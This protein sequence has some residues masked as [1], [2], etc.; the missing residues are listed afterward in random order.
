M[1]ETILATMVTPLMLATSPVETAASLEVPS[2]D[3]V[4]QEYN[5]QTQ[6]VTSNDELEEAGKSS[7]STRGTTSFVSG[8]LT[9]DDANGD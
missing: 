3:K 1:L 9:I 2:E 6:N 5:W 7:W 8:S 4:T